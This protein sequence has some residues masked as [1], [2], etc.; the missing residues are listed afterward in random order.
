[1][2]TESMSERLRSIV[3]DYLTKHGV[4]GKAHLCIAIDRSE[5]TLW[6]WRNEGV[7]S[8]RE[9]FKLAVACGLNEEEALKLAKEECPSEEAREA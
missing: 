5:V 2:H 7:P 1:M 6:R 8:T 4:A 9:A 3:D